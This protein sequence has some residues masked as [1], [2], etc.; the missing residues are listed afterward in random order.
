[1]FRELIMQALPWEVRCHHGR[2][3]TDNEQALN[4]NLRA[5]KQRHAAY[6]DAQRGR[7]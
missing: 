4:A 6:A 7:A 2:F 3:C 1:M 5:R